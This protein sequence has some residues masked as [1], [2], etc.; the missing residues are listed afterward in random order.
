[1]SKE[2]RISV[3]AL[4]ACLV[5]G[6]ANYGSVDGVD[7]LWREIPVSDFEVGT[8]TQ[9][10]VLQKLGPPSQLINLDN[11]VVF[12]YLAR[13]QTGKGMIFIVWNDV[14]E[15]NRYDRAIFFFDREG[16]LTNVAYSDE[17]IAR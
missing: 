11:E 10:D 6:C 5:T 4:L 14:T 13:R 8:T 16:L 12:Y 9:S 15:V 3:L 2:I 17:A 7:N 1:V